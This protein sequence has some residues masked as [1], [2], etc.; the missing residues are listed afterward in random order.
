LAGN[1]Y[2]YSYSK[3]FLGQVLTDNFLGLPNLVFCPVQAQEVK[4]NAATALES[5][6]SPP[7][8]TVLATV[9]PT[10]KNLRHK[11]QKWPH[12]NLR[13]LKTLPPKFLQICQKM[14][15]KWPNFIVVSSSQKRRP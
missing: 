6:F 10:V 5:I 8:S 7:H 12:E 1:I 11:T 2:S 9:L 4:R 14:P 13:G 15:Q 3:V